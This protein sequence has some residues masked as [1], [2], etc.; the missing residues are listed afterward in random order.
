MIFNGRIALEYGIGN[1]PNFFDNPEVVGV[2]AF[3]G[4]SSTSTPLAA[5]ASFAGVYPISPGNAGASGIIEE[6]SSL[7]PVDNLVL[8][9]VDLTTGQKRIRDTALVADRGFVPGI[10]AW[11]RW[12]N[13]N[14]KDEN[15][16][17][18]ALSANQ[19]LHFV[20]GTPAS[21]V[22][23]SGTYTYNV[24]GG[25]NPTIADGSVAP[26]TLSAGSRVAIAFAPLITNSRVGL[27]LS[28]GI[29]GGTY[30]ILTLGG[31][32]TPGSSP[33]TLTA[34]GGFSGSAIPVTFTG[35]GIACPSICT[36]S[37]DGFI[38]GP[39]ATHL[40]IVYQFGSVTAPT[41]MVT[42]AGA[43]GRPFP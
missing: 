12:T 38:A 31:V 21:N 42:G 25:T 1:G 37:V 43:F 6:D 10:I 13:G 39:F 7:G 16:T 33:I 3:A 24:I 27:D 11:E 40:G 41:K 19:G 8:R 23:T 14:V 26:G 18:I 22:P 29:G 5:L 32:V 2:A 4:G 34:T 36:A 35:A 28:V 15:N 17:V 20:T 30:N 9:E